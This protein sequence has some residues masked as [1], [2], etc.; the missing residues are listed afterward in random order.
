MSAE[1]VPTARS[2]L[3]LIFE[4]I[5][6]VTGLGILTM[7]LAPL[8][9]P[10]IVLIVVPAM[11]LGLVGGLAAAVVALPLLLVRW[12]VVA[13]VRRSGGGTVPVAFSARATPPRTP[14]EGVASEV[15][16]R[17]AQTT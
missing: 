4:V 7:A 3:D 17:P 1:Q 8:A 11:V 5:D 15:S 13:V 9:I 12:V 14:R 2:A 10:G 6:F 16:R